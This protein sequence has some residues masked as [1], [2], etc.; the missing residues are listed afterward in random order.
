[1]KT[2]KAFLAVLAASVACLDGGPGERRSAQEH[3]AGARRLGRR[4]GLEAGLR[5]PHQGRLQRHHGAGT[6]NLVR[7]RRRRDQAGPRPAGRSDAPRRPQLWRLD[8]HRGRRPSERRRASSMSPRTRPMSA[9]T[10]ATLGK[11][12]PSVLAK[13]DGCDQEDAGWLHLSRSGG[14]SQ[15]VRARSAARAGGVRRRARRCWRPPTS[16]AR[17]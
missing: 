8:H 5:H 16:S 6:R 14:V 1:M 9:R 11:K 10:K 7:R 2:F 4:V 15:A 17:R 3:R 12:T 13:T